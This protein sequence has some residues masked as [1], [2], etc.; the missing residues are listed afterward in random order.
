M[1]TFFIMSIYSKK[2]PGDVEYSISPLP[3]TPLSP[4]ATGDKMVSN[5]HSWWLRPDQLNI[6]SKEHCLPSVPHPFFTST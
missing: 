3:V 5:T 6:K 2:Y 1:Y 4:Q